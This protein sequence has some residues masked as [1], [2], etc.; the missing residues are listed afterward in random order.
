MATATAPKAPVLGGSKKEVSLETSVFAVEVKP[1]LV[2]ET[3][4]AE[5]NAARAGTRGAKSRGFVAGARRAR[6]GP[7]Q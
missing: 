6:A 1:H 4:R 3:V 5:L 2:H 7:A